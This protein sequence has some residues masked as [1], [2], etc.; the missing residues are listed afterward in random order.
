MGVL[1]AARPGWRGCLDSGLR[2]VLVP[3]FPGRAGDK[4]HL[5]GESTKALP[6]AL[7]E[8]VTTLDAERLP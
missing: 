2:V 8:W 3:P 7:A 4:A 5:G 6:T 1:L